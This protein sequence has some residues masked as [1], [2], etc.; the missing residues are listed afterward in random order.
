MQLMWTIAFMINTFVNNV[1][2]L[3]NNAYI[4][5]EW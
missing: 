2:H 3:L 4:S 5:K 1:L